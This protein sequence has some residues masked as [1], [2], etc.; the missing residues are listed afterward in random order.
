MSDPT[1]DSQYV[2]IADE[3]T[4]SD[5]ETDVLVRHVKTPKGER[6]EVRSATD[7]IRIDAMGLES[8]S[9]QDQDVFGEFLDREYEFPIASESDAATETITEFVISNEYAD[10]AVRVLETAEGDR[11]VLEAP[12]KQYSLQADPTCLDALAEQDSTIFS[13]FLETPHGPDGH[14]H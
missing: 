6:L 5:G 12:K 7:A 11:L 4:L 10:V 13:A 1:E 8:L 3:T 14:A 2:E 9:W